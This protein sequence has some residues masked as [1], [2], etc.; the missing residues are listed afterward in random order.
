MSEADA[1]DRGP[2]SYAG[3]AAPFWNRG[4]LVSHYARFPGLLFHQ[5]SGINAISIFFPSYIRIEGLWA[6]RPP[7][8]VWEAS[9]VTNLVFTSVGLSTDRPALYATNSAV[10]R[11]IGYIASLK[12]VRLRSFY[13]SLFPSY[14]SVFFAFSAAHA[15]RSRLYELGL[16]RRDLSESLPAR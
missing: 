3:G 5:M 12:L 2:F 10:R 14:P 7:C 1:I 4:L 13:S 9:G 8:C 6:Q 15:H 16:H 11:I